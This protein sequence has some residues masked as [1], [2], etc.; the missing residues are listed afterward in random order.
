VSYSVSTI[1]N[2]HSSQHLFDWAGLSGIWTVA[3][4]AWFSL[5]ETPRRRRG[6]LALAA[7]AWV[8]LCLLAAFGY[9]DSLL[10]WLER[11]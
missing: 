10:D 1:V 7:I 2:V 11:L 3:I 9:F 5:E 4:W 8:I 6:T